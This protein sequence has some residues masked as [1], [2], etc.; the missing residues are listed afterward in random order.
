MPNQSFITGA[1]RNY[2]KSPTGV[3]LQIPLAVTHEGEPQ[4]AAA[5]VLDAVREHDKV[6]T[7]PRP[8]ILYTAFGRLPSGSPRTSLQITAWLNDPLHIPEVTSELLLTVRDALA[9][10]DMDLV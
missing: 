3:R 9:V 7:Y 5:I 4:Q 2:S 1:I 8:A 6:L 10:H